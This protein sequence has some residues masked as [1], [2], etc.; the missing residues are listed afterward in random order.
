MDN[1]YGML[2]YLEKLS[3]LFILLLGVGFL[4]II[5]MYIV[6]KTQNKHAIRRNYP[7]IGRFRYLFE[8]QGE[9]F[10]QYFFAMDREELPFNRAERS[11]VYRAAKDV[12][13]TVAFGSTRNLEPTGTI[14]FMNC[15]FPTL[16][17]D[18]VPPSSI[19]YGPYCREPYT[20]ESLFNIS[21]M[22]F[23]ALSA[24]AVK[25]LSNGAAKAGCWMN[26][27]EGG[28]SEYHLASGADLVFQIG[29]AKYGV[30]D[31]HGQLCDKMLVTLAAK[32]QIKMFEI[33]L[34][35]GAKPGK[36]GILPGK[37]VTAEIARIRGIM[38]GVDSISP[39]AH[40]DIKSVQDILVM[41]NRVREVTG[42]PVGFKAVIGESL[43]LRALLEEINL[44]GAEFA[45][46]FITIDSAD[47]GTGAAPQPLMDY[48]GLPLKESLPLVVNLL[49]E[50]GLR[51]RIR[52]ICAGKLI[53][54]SKVAWAL[55]MG[56]DAVNSARGFMF[57]LGCIQAMQCNKDTCPT[58]I[59]TH[60]IKL[61]R[62]LDPIDKAERVANYH[63]YIQYGVGLLAHS[64]GVRHARKLDRHHIRIIQDNGLSI[65]LDKLHPYDQT[66]N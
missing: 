25:A 5:Y 50:Y 31:E 23:G 38:P 20:S 14:M 10:R 39:N 15:A 13:R 18:A 32:S 43:W 48:V 6:D 30:R 36:G 33:K 44:Q 40:P 58:G 1:M 3:A 59:T 41:V 61:Q 62:G 11:W 19:T 7:V 27:G 65:A 45:P 60:N 35:Q 34:S 17:E 66:D 37:K 63:K 21:A 28:I 51:D 49:A 47:G 12:E 24:T 2:S 26:T 4:A 16:E 52:V 9:F 57:A 46:D 53:T 8:K 55:A 42:K 54:P 56:A 64:C 29:T 22:S